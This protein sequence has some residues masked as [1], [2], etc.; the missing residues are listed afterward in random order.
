[1]ATLHLSLNARLDG[2]QPAE[3][4][5]SL[6]R[7]SSNPIFQKQSCLLMHKD[8][9]P[10]HAWQVVAHAMAGIAPETKKTQGAG[11]PLSRVAR[12]QLKWEKMMKAIEDSGSAVDVLSNRKEDE[13]ISKSDVLG[14]LIR[15]RQLN[16][17]A[18]VLEVLI[19]LKEQD[20]WNF[21]IQDFNLIIAAYGKLGQ[22]GNAESSFTEMRE[23]GLEPNVACFTSLLEAHA[24]ADNFERAESI[25]REMVETGPAPTEVTYQVYINAL[26]KAERFD[27]AERIFNSMGVKDEAKPDAR[28]YNLMIH[29]YGKARKFS[30]QQSLFRRMKGSGVPMTA[31][32]FNSLMA[33]QKTVEDAEACLRH[34]QAAKIKPDVITYTGLINAYSKAR[35]VEEAQAVFR[36]MVASGIKPSRTAYNT[37]LDAYARCK[38]VEGAESLFKKMGQDRCRPDV[39]SYTTLLA[40]YANSGNMK[41]AEQLLKRMKQAGLEPNVVTYG[42]LMLGYTSV[43]DTTALLRTFEELKK[44]GIKPNATIFTLL[45]RTS[46]QQEK[47]SDALSWFKMMVESGCSADQRSRAAL[48]DACQT[49]E[50]KEE[51]LD[52]FGTLN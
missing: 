9:S 24:R 17:W 11:E 19:W 38:E 10:R 52:Y 49:S 16:K 13:K 34:M 29:T 43:H 39:H 23:A 28:L 36:E 45:I 30:E 1:M 40:A 51:V 32:T 50:Q 12:K 37:L 41:K 26:C 27:D 46:G 22:P 8:A 4:N 42:T 33:F 48:M 6:I 14:T 2:C 3:K 15:L 5:K 44:A 47:F 31:V 7:G 18:M 20:W 35:R 25:Y 21:G